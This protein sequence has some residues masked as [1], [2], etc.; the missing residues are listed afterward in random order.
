MSVGD[1]EWLVFNG[2]S[3]SQCH[4]V[5][6]TAPPTPQC[7]SPC[8]H[9]PISCTSSSLHKGQGPLAA[10][11]APWLRPESW[12]MGL[13]FGWACISELEWAHPEKFPG[14]SDVLP[15]RP[16][17]QRHP[18]RTA[19]SAGCHSCGFQDGLHSSWPDSLGERSGLQ[20][21]GYRTAE[22]NPASARPARAPMA[23]P[24]NHLL[25]T[26]ALWDCNRNCS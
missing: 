7:R 22:S 23:P 4:C 13:A 25:Q 6:D 10:T 14:V 21:P 9:D 8:E 24:R 20:K 19:Q 17:G 5:R 11:G 16:S 26:T 2:L 12:R 3:V 18:R 1:G 15:R